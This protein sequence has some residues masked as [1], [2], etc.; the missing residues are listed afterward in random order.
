MITALPSSRL[1]QWGAVCIG[2]LL[3]NLGW[4]SWGM[5][6]PWSEIVA[7]GQLRVAVKD[8]IVPLGFRNS[9]GELV[10]FE[11]DLAREL[12]DHLLGS[13]QAVELVPVT[14]VER[15]GAVI[16][17]RVDI[18]IAQVGI[19]AN[20]TRQV[21]FSAPYY[22]DGTGIAVAKATSIQSWADLEGQAVAVLEFSDAIPYLNAQLPEAEL[23]PIPTYAVGAELLLADAVQG[24]AADLSVLSGWLAA[25]PDYELLQPPFSRIGLG[26]VLPKGESQLN[27]QVNRTIQQLERSGWLQEKAEEWGLP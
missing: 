9:E 7:A 22:Y 8:T 2:S 1:C 6:R 17:D 26:V 11:I 18:A 21:H 25:H 12:A 5:A 13:P 27:Q 20:R 14:N 19:T 23:I 4:G 16:S 3:F 10:G 15:I 24:F